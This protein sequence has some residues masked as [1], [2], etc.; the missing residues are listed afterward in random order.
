MEWRND[1][2]KVQEDAYGNEDGTSEANEKWSDCGS[3]SEVQMTGMA[4]EFWYEAQGE[5]SKQGWWLCLGLCNLVHDAET[6]KI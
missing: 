3:I 6:E 4:V 2:G 5:R 1:H